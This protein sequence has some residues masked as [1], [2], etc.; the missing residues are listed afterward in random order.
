MPCAVFVYLFYLKKVVEILFVCIK[1][2]YVILLTALV[3]IT[4]LKFPLSI[5]IF[6]VQKYQPYASDPNLSGALASV[7][8]ELDLLSKHYHPSVSTLASSIASI[9]TAHNQ[10][11]LSSISPQQAFLDLSLE[12]VSFTPQSHSMKLN[13]KRKRGSGSSTSV[14]I[15]PAPDPASIDED[16]VRN[17][18]STHFML[19]RDIKEN[20]RLRAE[21]DRTTLYVQL[22]EEHKQQ[23]KKP[24]TKTMLVWKIVGHFV[25]FVASKN[26]GNFC[27][28]YFGILRFIF[29][30]PLSLFASSYS[31][32]IDLAGT[33]SIHCCY[34]TSFFLF[35]CI[36]FS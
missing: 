2:D 34:I 19:L 33:T 3:W 11:F 29:L 15:D 9:S 17:K 23:K 30:N 16:K 31:P 13:N 6:Y 28:A 36:F 10:V 20:E 22:Y 26:F 25:I 35:F 27:N 5:Y 21:L 32:F 12:R 14:T 8:W 24:R 4:N 1:V 7:L 18:L